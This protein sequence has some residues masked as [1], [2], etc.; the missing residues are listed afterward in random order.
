MHSS[1]ATLVQI[2]YY[3]TF[4]L[5]VGGVAVAMVRSRSSRSWIDA[6]ALLAFVG[7]T[8]LE[9]WFAA[10]E[11]QG[12]PEMLTSSQVL[13]AALLQLQFGFIALLYLAVTRRPPWKPMTE[14]RLPWVKSLKMGALG[15]MAA[16]VGMK[17]AEWVLYGFVLDRAPPDA[18]DQLVVQSLLQSDNATLRWAIVVAAGVVAPVVEEMLYRGFL[19]RLCHGLMG[20]G[21][22]LGISSA[23]FALAHNDAFLTVPL[24]LLGLALGR[25]YEVTGRLSVPILMHAAF[26]LLNLWM[27]M[28]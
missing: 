21:L 12:A 2:G 17:V 5:L 7:L 14:P 15:L 3:A 22:A 28:E 25:T 24:L 19:L 26:N 6:I 11:P 8:G 1:P 18:S 9:F 20:S 10:E 23:V 27:L 16:V 13:A 4:A